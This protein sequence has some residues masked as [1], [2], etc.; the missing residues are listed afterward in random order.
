[1]VVYRVLREDIAMSNVTRSRVVF[2]VDKVAVGQVLL[3]VLLLSSLHIIP[4]NLSTN[5]KLYVVF[6]VHLITIG[7]VYFSYQLVHKIL[8]YY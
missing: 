2:M 3:R 6:T 8:Q 7:S 4:L 1:M 5:F